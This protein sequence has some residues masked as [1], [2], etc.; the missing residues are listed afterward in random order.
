MTA[1]RELYPPLQPYD[2][3]FLVRGEHRIYYEQ[4][5]NPRGKPALFVHGGPGGGGDENARRFFDPDGYRIINFD[6]RGAGRS[7]PAA[8]L[9]DNTTWALTADMEA[10]RELLEIDRWLVFGGSWGSTLALA[11]AQSYPAAVSQLVLRGI[12]LL[13]RRELDWFYQNGASNLFPE[14]WQ[15]FIAPIPAA[16]RDDLLA[17]YHRRLTGEDERLRMQAARA[18]S[19]WEGATSSLLANEKLVEHFSDPQFALALARIETHYFVNGGFL[20]REDQLLAGAARIRH[21]PGVIV[22]GRYDV[23]CPIM[24]A[25]ELAQHWPEA[26]FRIVADAG[27]SAYEPG[28]TH[29]LIR[30]TDEF[31]SVDQQGADA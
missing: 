23:V 7:R 13:R 10:L 18:W 5:G 28:I 11:Y 14:Q 29:E 26:S 20:E 30:A 17:A 19:I 16:E 31:L 27:H 1:R 21:I 25:W 4:C 2:Q 9:D 8:S 24:T 12:F 22:Q 6:Q 15:Q 3:G